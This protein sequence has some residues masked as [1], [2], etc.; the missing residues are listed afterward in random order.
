MSRLICMLA[1]SVLCLCAIAGVA[2][3][4][5]SKAPMPPPPA[6]AVPEAPA[7]AVSPPWLEPAK[8]ISLLK[9]AGKDPAAPTLTSCQGNC[10]QAKN[11]GV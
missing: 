10:V 8:A 7:T 9:P 6:A 2:A 5:P 3:S 4:D 11:K 1:L